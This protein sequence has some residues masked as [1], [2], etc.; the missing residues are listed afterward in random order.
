VVAHSI[1]TTSFATDT[2]QANRHEAKEAKLLSGEE[3]GANLHA[4]G[5]QN[6]VIGGKARKGF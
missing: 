4:R 2:L 5:V 6:F 3:L 1:S